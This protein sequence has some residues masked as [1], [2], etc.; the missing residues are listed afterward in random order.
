[1]DGH[2]PPAGQR[3]GEALDGAGARGGDDVRHAGVQLVRRGPGQ[4]AAQLRDPALQAGPS[5]SGARGGTRSDLLVASCVATGRRPGGDLL[6]ASCVATG[7]SLPSTDLS[8]FPQKPTQHPIRR[9][10]FG[11]WGEWLQTRWRTLQKIQHQVGFLFCPK[12][13]KIHP[14]RTK[15]HTHTHARSHH[16]RGGGSHPCRP[17]AKTFRVAGPRADLLAA[18]HGV[19]R[20]GGVVGVAEA[21]QGDDRPW[22]ALGQGRGGPGPH[23]RPPR[24]GC[25]APPQ[26]VHGVLRG[27]HVRH[28]STACEAG[29]SPGPMTANLQ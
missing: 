2:D 25:P 28:W 1:M 20:Q 9:G 8:N 18:L 14:K 13:S 26:S 11:S 15:R 29:F 19:H 3:G 27:C 12:R 16:R 23:R 5:R 4:R 17:A 24:D 21:G 7:R 6:A 22:P 10:H